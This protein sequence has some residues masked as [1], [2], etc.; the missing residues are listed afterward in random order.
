MPSCCQLNRINL[1]SLTN[2]PPGKGGGL[3]LDSHEKIERDQ[4]VWHE[5]KS[6][7]FF[8]WNTP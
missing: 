1:P 7:F 8:G 5:V 2:A 4:F 6:E 3:P